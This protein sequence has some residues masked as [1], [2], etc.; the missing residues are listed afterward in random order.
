[1]LKPHEKYCSLIF[2]EM[3]LQPGLQYNQKLD[4]AE[5]FENYG[6]SERKA[7]FAD[8]ALVFM[9]RGVYKNWEQ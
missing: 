1:M 6:D 9:L 8:H 4:L 5:G 2:D 3:A 7:S